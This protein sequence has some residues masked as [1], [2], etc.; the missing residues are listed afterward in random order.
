MSVGKSVR[1][2]LMR[3]AVPVL[4]V[5]ALLPSRAEELV[6]TS[7]CASLGIT[8]LADQD[9]DARISLS[10]QRGATTLARAE[11]VDVRVA[12]KSK[13]QHSVVLRLAAGNLQA[14]ELQHGQVTLR[15]TGVNPE[16]L[17]VESRLDFGYAERAQEET[18][19]CP[20]KTDR[21]V[22]S[23]SVSWTQ[24]TSQAAEKTATFQGVW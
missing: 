5:V 6:L 7:A 15:I 21:R 20:S 16:Q 10:L 12:A 22:E 24:K 19:R 13:H 11:N 8:S 18:P 9:A 2:P 23:K 17:S 3:L 1:A 14:S 4:A